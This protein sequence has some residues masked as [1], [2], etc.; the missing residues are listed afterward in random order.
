MLIFFVQSFKFH[1][2]LVWYMVR[3]KLTIPERWKAVCM[4]IGG[5][6]HRSVADHFK[7]TIPTLYDWCSVFVKRGMLLTVHVQVDLAKRRRERTGSYPERTWSRPFSTVGALRGNLAFGGHIITRPV[8]RRLHHHG[9]RARRPIKPPQLTL[10]HRHARFDWSH[11]HLGWTIRTWRRV[12]WSDES[13]FFV[14]PYRRLCKG[15]A[16]T[17]HFISGQPHFGNNCFWGWGVT[18]WGCFSFDCKLDLYVLD[19]NL[20][21][22][23]YRHNVLAPRVVPHFDNHALADRP[24]F[25]DDNAR[26]H[27]ARSVQHFLQQEAVQTI[28]W[29]AMSPDMNLLE[30]VWDFIDR[31]SNQRN[32]KCQTIDELRTAILQEWQQFPQERLRRLVRSMTRRVTELQNKRGGYTRYLFLCITHTHNRYI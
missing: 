25:M 2:L 12:H 26:P 27:K 13:R 30:H 4:Y 7:V 19:G 31:K 14:A 10:R 5:F 18:I 23:K 16:P 3:R 17:K 6:C 9:M 32:P 20:T 15:L 21:G 8:I 28:P 1:F 24:I 29:P 11:D 22:Q